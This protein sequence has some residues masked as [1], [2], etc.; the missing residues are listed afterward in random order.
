MIL[1]ILFS[2]QIKEVPFQLNML[3]SKNQYLQCTKLLME[4]LQISNN[5]LK[6]IDALNELRVELKH[7][8]QVIHM[9]KQSYNLYYNN[10]VFPPSLI[11]CFFLSLNIFYDFGY[12]YNI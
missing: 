11:I 7:K 12:Q 3:E 8:K 6:N 9:Y 5:D 4:T 10:D 2:E 1:Y